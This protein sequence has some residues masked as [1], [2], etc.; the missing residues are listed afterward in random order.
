MSID[1]VCNRIVDTTFR[2]N[3]GGSGVFVNMY[4]GSKMVIENTL[5]NSYFINDNIAEQFLIYVG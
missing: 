1:Y 2:G 3:K 5:P 4:G